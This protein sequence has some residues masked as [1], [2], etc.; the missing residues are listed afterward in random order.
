AFSVKNEQRFAP[1]HDSFFTVKKNPRGAWEFQKQATLEVLR[2]FSAEGKPVRLLG[3]PSFI[4]ELIEALKEEGPIRLP[5]KNYMLTGGGWKAAE[6]KQIT[7]AA[8]RRLVTEY[9]GIPD[10]NMRDGYGMAEHSAPY[11]ECPQ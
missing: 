11:I 6:D 7:R 8:F 9:L 3:I 4:Y 5:P 2:R 10:E 1:A